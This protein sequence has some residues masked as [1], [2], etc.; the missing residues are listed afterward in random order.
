MDK[1]EIGNWVEAL[2]YIKDQNGYPLFRPM[3]RFE[4][5]N[6]MDLKIVNKNKKRLKLIPTPEK[7]YSSEDIL[8]FLNYCRDCNFMIISDYNGFVKND[9]KTSKSFYEMLDEWK[10]KNNTNG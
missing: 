6:S 4:I 1:F 7:I 2:D 5:K 8:S 10:L 3:N 9:F